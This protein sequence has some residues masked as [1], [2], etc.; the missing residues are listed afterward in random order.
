MKVEFHR[1]AEHELI[2]AAVRYETE[3]AGLGERFYSELRAACAVISDYPEI[4]APIDSELRKLVLERFPYSLIY[5]ASSDTIYVL[6]IAHERLPPGYWAGRS[7][8]QS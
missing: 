4:G 3:V 5:A 2:N 8:R 1:D 6:A 7:L